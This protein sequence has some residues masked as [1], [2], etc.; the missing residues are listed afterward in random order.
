MG[1]G[2]GGGD[3]FLGSQVIYIYG[4]VELDLLDW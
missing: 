2:G 3:Y 1:G 4:H